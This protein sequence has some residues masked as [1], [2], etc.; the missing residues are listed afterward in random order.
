MR[1]LGFITLLGTLL[2]SGCNTTGST[3][4]ST[5][6]VLN[7]KALKVDTY[8]SLNPEC[9]STGSTSIRVLEQ[10]KHGQVD[11]KN[12]MDFSTYPKENIRVHCNAKR[13]PATQVFYTPSSG[14]KGPDTFQVEAVFPNGSTRIAR[15]SLDVR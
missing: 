8:G 5:K 12:A 11:L 6:V 14:Y 2:V 4:G 9:V 15:Y 3:S 1:T 13:T 7:G 10:P